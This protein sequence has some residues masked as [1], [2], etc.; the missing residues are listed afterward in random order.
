ML[1]TCMIKYLG[2]NYDF[3]LFVFFIVATG[4][5]TN[6]HIFAISFGHFSYFCFC[7]NQIQ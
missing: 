1:P 6:L 2:C 5:K 3:N 4:V 7:S